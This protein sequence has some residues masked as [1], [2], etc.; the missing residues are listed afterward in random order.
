MLYVERPHPLSGSLILGVVA[1]G[2]TC[3]PTAPTAQPTPT[4]YV[5]VRGL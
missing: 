5:S 1:C 2:Q 4:P 3:S